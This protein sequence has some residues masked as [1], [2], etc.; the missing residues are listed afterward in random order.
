[1][2]N[3][4][5]RTSSDCEKYIESNFSA[6]KSVI[7][8]VCKKLYHI[9]S[10]CEECV[11]DLILKIVEN[12]YEILRSFP[13]GNDYKIAT[14][15][16]T[17]LYRKAIDITR[18]DEG[19]YRPSTKAKK[20]GRCT[21]E[22]EKQL[23][24][25][26]SLQEAHQTMLNIEECRNITFDD[27]QKIEN[28]IRRK[29]GKPKPTTEYVSDIN[30]LYGESSDEYPDIT[31]GKPLNEHLVDGVHNK[32]PLENFE[33]E[34]G[35]EVRKQFQ[36]LMASFM[37]KLKGED[38]IIFNMSFFKSVNVSQIARSIN[39]ERYFVATKIKE[40]LEDFKELLIKNDLSL[41]DLKNN[42]NF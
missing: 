19:Q 6:L 8:S 39:Q 29:T 26:S 41:E 23:Y 35:N 28:K 27:A 40:L 13:G 5:F 7:T 24:Y 30:T 16:F 1:M 2:E 42:Y 20:L 37:D 36:K 21:V 4:V 10:D 12:D 14:Y 18:G 31:T 11:S 22:L 33:E 34:E 3:S 25:G 38:L 15:L 9:V 32:D 17:V